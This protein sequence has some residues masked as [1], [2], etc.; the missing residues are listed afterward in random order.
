[1]KGGGS[2]SSSSTYMFLFGKNS[3][4]FALNG[5][6]AIILVSQAIHHECN[7]SF[8]VCINLIYIIH[9]VNLEKKGRRKKEEEED[10][11]RRTQAHFISLE[12]HQCYSLNGSETTNKIK[13]KAC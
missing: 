8:Q 4:R 6:Q 13:I 10:F 5:K 9:L 2:S 3:K 12:D 11:N 7:P 1:M